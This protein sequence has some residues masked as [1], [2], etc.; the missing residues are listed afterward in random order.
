V[1]A[2]GWAFG[3]AVVAIIV[4]MAFASLAAAQDVTPTPVPTPTP[5]PAPPSVPSLAGEQGGFIALTAGL[6]IA[7]AL[8]GAGVVP[9]MT[10]LVLQTGGMSWGAIWVGYLVWL[11]SVARKYLR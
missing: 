2:L 1:R 5:T 10:V 9:L 7:C 6:G 11:L 8:T 3:S 4:A